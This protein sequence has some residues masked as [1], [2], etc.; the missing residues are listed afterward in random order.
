MEQ[1]LPYLLQNNAHFT[2]ILCTVH[3]PMLLL[4]SPQKKALIFLEWHTPLYDDLLF[5]FYNILINFRHM[6]IYNICH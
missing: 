5:L 1:K 4:Q 6:L 2:I 3:K